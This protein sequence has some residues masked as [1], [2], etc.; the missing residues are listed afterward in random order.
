MKK[1]ER[2]KNENVRKVRKWLGVHFQQFRTL[3]QSDQLQ[4]RVEVTFAQRSAGYVGTLPHFSQRT[5]F[6]PRSGKEIGCSTCGNRF[7]IVIPRSTTTPS[8][9]VAIVGGAERIAIRR[10]VY[11]C[12][13]CLVRLQVW[14]SKTWCWIEVGV[15]LYSVLQVSFNSIAVRPHC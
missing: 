7:L 12:P 15:M 3:C 10:R 8:T 9:V 13:A 14:R 4:R 11:F 2:E 5:L 1:W 6:Q